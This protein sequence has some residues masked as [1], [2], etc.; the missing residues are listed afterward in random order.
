MSLLF[1]DCYGVGCLWR[2][3][4]VVESSRVD[5]FSMSW[6]VLLRVSHFRITNLV[7][8]ESLKKLS[9]L[10]VSIGDQS[11]NWSKIGSRKLGVTKLKS[12]IV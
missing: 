3:E 9:S 11:S 1:V 8:S 5:C 10:A 7:S 2:D 12:H 4:S 6:S